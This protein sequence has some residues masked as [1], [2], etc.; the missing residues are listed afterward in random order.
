MIYQAGFINFLRTIAI[1]IGVIYILRFLGR[2]FF[3]ILL[4]RAVN[5]QQERYNQYN[6]HANNKNKETNDPVKDKHLSDNIGEYVE[7]EEVNE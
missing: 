1:I 2:I 4:K 6:G 5:K 3:P 7:Y